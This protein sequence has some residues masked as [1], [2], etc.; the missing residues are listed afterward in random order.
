MILL[1]LAITG[2]V[3]WLAFVIFGVLWWGGASSGRRRG[4]HLT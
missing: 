1:V 2:H 4:R 3:P